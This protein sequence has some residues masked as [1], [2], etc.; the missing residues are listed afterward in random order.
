MGRLNGYLFW[1]YLQNSA[2]IEKVNI[3]I[4]GDMGVFKITPK[5]T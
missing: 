4:S 5:I 3:T 2:I 1:S